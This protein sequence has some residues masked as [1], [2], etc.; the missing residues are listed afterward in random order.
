[1][2][3]ISISRDSQLTLNTGMRNRS[4]I[5]L[6]NENEDCLWLVNERRREKNV[7]MNDLVFFLM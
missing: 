2:S 5:Y 3:P 1:M 6:V 4:Q 7:R